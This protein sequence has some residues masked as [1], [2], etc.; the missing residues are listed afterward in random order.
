MSPGS[1]DREAVGP[2]HLHGK[3]PRAKPCIGG[4]VPEIM[5]KLLVWTR[6]PLFVVPASLSHSH[7]EYCEGEWKEMGRERD[8]QGRPQKVG[9]DQLLGW[10]VVLVSGGGGW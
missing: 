2:R 9:H 1:G 5:H 3:G 4:R 8:N 10:N 7:A 6:G